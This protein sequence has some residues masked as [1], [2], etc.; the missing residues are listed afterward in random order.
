MTKKIFAIFCVVCFCVMLFSTVAFAEERNCPFGVKADIPSEYQFDEEDE[1]S[2]FFTSESSMSMIMVG[3]IEL[4]S[5]Q[6]L[7]K[8]MKKELLN[9]ICDDKDIN[10]DY[11]NNEK[12]GNKK[13]YVMTGTMSIEDEIMK[14]YIYVFQLKNK[15]IFSLCVC[16]PDDTK[17]EKIFDKVIESIY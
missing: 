17:R 12:I 11:E 1:D 16:R 2:I 8:D 14:A 15:V 3:V 13:V 4:E 6:K 9:A 10:I 7:D 5:G